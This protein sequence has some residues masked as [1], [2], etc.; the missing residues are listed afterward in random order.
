MRPIHPVL[1]YP[2]SFVDDHI[3]E[4]ESL[5]SSLQRERLRGGDAGVSGAVGDEDRGESFSREVREGVGCNGGVEERGDGIERKGRERE[6]ES[7]LSFADEDVASSSKSSRKGRET[8]EKEDFQEKLRDKEEVR[9]QLGCRGSGI[10]GTFTRGSRAGREIRKGPRTVRNDSKRESSRRRGRRS[11]D[12][13]RRW[14]LKR[15]IL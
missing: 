14:V 11:K 6:G 3:F 5:E 9:R 7:E 8:H 4:P 10:R 15:G 12:E 1:P 2:V 13:R